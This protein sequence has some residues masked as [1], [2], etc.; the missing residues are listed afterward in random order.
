NAELVLEQ[1]TN[2]TNAAVAEV[3]NVIHRADVLAQL[4]QILDGGVEVVRIQRSL[5]ER[6][7]I[8]VLEQLDVELQPAH[9]R[10]VILPRIEE[11]S[12]EESGRGIE[13]RR[14]AGTQLAVNLDQRFLRRLHRVAL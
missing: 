13:R 10:E 12:V 5:V 4:Q 14:I 7:G 6:G 8:A 9:A 3:I 1:L 11:H 2:S